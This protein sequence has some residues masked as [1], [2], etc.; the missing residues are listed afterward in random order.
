MRRPMQA[1]PP[2]Q[3][4]DGLDRTDW[5]P[6]DLDPTLPGPY[7]C[8][9]GGMHIYMRTWTGATWLSPI[10]GIP[11]KVRMPWRGIKPGSLPVEKFPGAVRAELLA[12]LEALKA[13]RE[14]TP[15]EIMADAEKELFDNQFALAS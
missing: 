5:L 3:A 12:S 6:Q 2:A 7:E 13:Q 15:E 11:S 1:Q 10:T 8:A 9:T 4:D 14:P